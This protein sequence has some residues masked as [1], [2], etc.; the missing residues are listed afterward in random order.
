[1]KTPFFINIMQNS[2]KP[3][4]KRL[5]P[6]GE[7]D[8]MQDNDLKHASG[9]AEKFMADNGITWDRTPA[10]SPDIN[11]MENIFAEMKWYLRS[12]VKPKTL[13]G[14]RHGIKKFWRT[15]DVNKCNRSITC[16]KLFL[17]LLRRKDI[18]LGTRLE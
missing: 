13:D 10:E 9:D 11:P 14:L 5:Y 12:K 18:Q 1:M 15:V 3:S 17:P 4:A 6:N 7:W 16:T 8:L 2:L